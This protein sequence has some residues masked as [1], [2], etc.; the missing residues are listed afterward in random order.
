M[1]ELLTEE[2]EG[3]Y[4]H[5]PLPEDSDGEQDRAPGK[6][7]APGASEVRT[8]LPLSPSRVQ[9]GHQSRNPFDDL[10]IFKRR[11][12]RDTRSELERYLAAPTEPTKNPVKWWWDHRDEY[13]RLSR[14]ALGYLTI[15]GEYTARF[16]LSFAH[17]LTAPSRSY[18]GR[19]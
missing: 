19:Y 3:K 17:N 5:L 1:R 7:D 13:P 15:P 14:M 2:Y 16:L 12:K 8:P 10:P 18:V 9:L 4:A 11:K 6:T